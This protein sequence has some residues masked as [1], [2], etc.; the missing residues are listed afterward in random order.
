LTGFTGGSRYN[1]KGAAVEP[2]CLPRDPEWGMYKDGTDGD[3]A[4]IYG[5]E[6]ETYTFLGNMRN[7]YEHD[8]PCAVCLIHQKSL[9]RMF[10]GTFISFIFFPKYHDFIILLRWHSSEPKVN[11]TVIVKPWHVSLYCRK[12]IVL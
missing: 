4:Y 2:L 9:L 10:P 8:V 5:A 3:K 7:L 11:G 12:E 1:H 6:Y